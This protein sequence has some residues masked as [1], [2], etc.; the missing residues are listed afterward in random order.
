MPRLDSLSSL[1]DL[2]GAQL[3][4][5]T[6]R[7]VAA[8]AQVVCPQATI[9]ELPQWEPVLGIDEWLSLGGHLVTAESEHGGNLHEWLVEV[10]EEMAG[11]IAMDEAFEQAGL[12][13]LMLI[14]LAR[15]L[16]AK[17]GKSV[18]VA[19]LYDNPTPQ[20]LLDSFGGGP[21]PQLQRPKVVCLHGFRS[22]K[23]AMAFQ[24]AP[25]VS[26]VG[27]VEWLFVNA[28]RAA[29]GEAAPKLD[30]AESFEWWGERGGSYERGWMAPHFG[31][32]EDTLPKVSSLA[33]V[34]VV[35]F[36]QGGAVA[37][38]LQCSWVAMFSAVVP[39][40][41]QQRSTPS[42]HSWDEQEEFAA[43]CAEVADCFGEKEVHCHNEGH[44]VPRGEDIVRTFAAWVA[45]QVG[46]KRGA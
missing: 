22:N 16:S 25:I 23:E 13:S 33:P 1:D 15:R 7:A 46:R 41:L 43:Q 44:N 2:N 8:L 42:F 32:L 3:V 27:S 10:V 31:G 4:L 14:S 29:S 40:G 17:I 6:S 28:S 30:A 5:S 21:R 36:S 12:D 9:V 37:A 35:G 34:G 26:A 38:L 45:V 20:R 24:M 11:P 19:D 39:P 18:S